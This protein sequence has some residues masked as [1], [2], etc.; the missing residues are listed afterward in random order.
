MS[1]VITNPEV[2]FSDVYL[3]TRVSKTEP[4]TESVQYGGLSRIVLTDQYVDSRAKLQR[5][6]LDASEVAD[7]QSA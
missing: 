4:Q 1:A 7:A 2:S 6:F 5:E 3:S